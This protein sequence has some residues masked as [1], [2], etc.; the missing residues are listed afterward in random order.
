MAKNIT[1]MENKKF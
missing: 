1:R